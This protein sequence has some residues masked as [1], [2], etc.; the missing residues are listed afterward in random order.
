MAKQPGND[1]LNQFR[2]RQLRLVLAALRPMDG[3]GYGLCKASG[4]EVPDPRLEL[5]PEAGL[6]VQTR[7]A[8]EG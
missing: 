6:C 3:R 2:D 1:I 4:D 5:C 7:Q 8:Q